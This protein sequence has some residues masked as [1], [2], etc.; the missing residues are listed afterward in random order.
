MNVCDGK[1]LLHYMYGVLTRVAIEIVAAAQRAGS[2]MQSQLDTSRSMD[3]DHPYGSKPTVTRSKYMQLMKIISFDYYVPSVIES[4]RHV[5][6]GT[7]KSARFR[8]RTNY[9]DYLH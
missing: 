2:S 1:L 9:R 4:R 5:I 3:H 8:C 6:S 7:T